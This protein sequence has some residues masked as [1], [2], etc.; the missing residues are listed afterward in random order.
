MFPIQALPRT[1]DFHQRLV[2]DSV[3]N[4][5]DGVL[6]I[7]AS[8]S[9]MSLDDPDRVTEWRAY[10]AAFSDEMLEREDRIQQTAE[11]GSKLTEEVA[12]ALFPHVDGP[13]N[14]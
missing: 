11:R 8:L 9:Y 2:I 5:G 6:T 1:E 10:W 14:H 13:Y 4:V 7:V 3:S 12:R